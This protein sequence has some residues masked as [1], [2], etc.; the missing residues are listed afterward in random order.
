MLRLS[1]DVLVSEVFC[2]K[3]I[4]LVGEDPVARFLAETTQFFNEMEK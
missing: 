2:E 1:V 3:S 4:V